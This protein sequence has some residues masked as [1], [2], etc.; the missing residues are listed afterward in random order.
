MKKITLIIPY[1]GIFPAYYQLFLDSCAHNEEIDWLIFTDNQQEY[2]YPP[3][4][5]TV[6]WTFEELKNYIG[7]KFDFSISLNEP[8][9]LCDYKPAYGY[10]FEDYL[11]ESDY[12]G[13]CD[14]DLIFGDIKKFI[15]E[16]CFEIYDKIGHL[17]HLTLYRNTQDINILFMQANIQKIFGNSQIFVF[18]EWGLENINSLFIK[19]GKKVLFWNSFLDVYP[20]D[21]NFK[22]IITKIERDNEIKISIYRNKLPF[23][24]AYYSGKVFQ[25]G[26]LLKKSKEFAYIHLQKRRMRVDFELSGNIRDE[27]VIIPERFCSRKKCSLIKVLIQESIHFFFNKK[28]IMH[29]YLV[30]KYWIIEKTG[31]I[32]H[33]IKRLR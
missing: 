15:N 16:E 19:N 26:I 25:E 21:D 1:F 29:G 5:H 31:F 22:R 11:K 12:W 30:C 14:L 8:Y 2:R 10:I 32:R 7:S 24:A 9:K 13:Y 28:R 23:I 18:D 4:V 17:G 3:N 6:F 27:Y 33:K 20:Y